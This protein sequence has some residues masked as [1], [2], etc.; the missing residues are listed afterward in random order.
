MTSRIAAAFE[1]ARR[2]GRAALIAY[3]TAYDGGPAASLACL[4]AA[5]TAGA[6]IIEL[7]VPFSDPTADGPAIQ[8]AMV[9]AR[10]AGATL[11][12]VLQLCEEL[13]RT[14]DI[15]IVLF[16]YANPI[17][18][19]G[20]DV[21]MRAA[22]AAGVDGVLVVDLPVESA[23][24]VRGP[25]RAAGLDWIGLVAPTSTA[26][27]SAA[28]VAGASGFVYAIT[29]RGVTGGTLGAGDDVADH[30][31]AIRRRSALPVAAGFGIRTPQDVR[32]L[33]SHADGIV[34]G[35]ALV[36]ASQAGPGALAALVMALRAATF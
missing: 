3:L 13:R 7:G 1:G 16:G 6:D 11:P 26:A 35:S 15:P 36:E 8:A 4:R 10:A 32:R 19:R 2:E 29:Q 5:A 24:L 23:D 27:R 9:R 22:A 12:R 34:V 31:A 28:I 25:A 18:R 17:V 30:L 33:V 14:S 20:V 21:A